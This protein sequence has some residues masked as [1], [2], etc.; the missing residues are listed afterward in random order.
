MIGNGAV[1]GAGRLRARGDH[2]R[3]RMSASWSACAHPVRTLLTLIGYLFF[4]RKPFL[5]PASAR[6]K[7]EYIFACG[8]SRDRSTP[9]GMG[10]AAVDISGAPWGLCRGA[11]IVC[12]FIVF[13]DRPA[14]GNKRQA[15]TWKQ[16]TGRHM[17]TR[18]RPAQGNKRHAGTWKQETGRHMETRDR[19]A[20]GNRREKNV[21]SYRRAYR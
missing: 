8:A 20:H 7:I 21:V 3:V 6:R 17:E 11:R 10:H 18:D 14:H 16:E 13:G 19:P 15:G 2:T 1:R 5:C 12:A 4:A 9:P